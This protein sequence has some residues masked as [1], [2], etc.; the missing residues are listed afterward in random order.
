LEELA[1]SIFWVEESAM[2]QRKSVIYGKKDWGYGRKKTHI[3]A[4]R[5]KL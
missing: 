2:K 5:G 4:D 3:L 1:V